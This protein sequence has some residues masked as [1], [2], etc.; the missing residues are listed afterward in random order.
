MQAG[1]HRLGVGKLVLLE[2]PLAVILLPIVIHHQ[3]SGGEP[4]VPNA[5][6][7]FQYINL[8][9]VIHQLDPG[10]ILRATKQQL[11]GHPR[12][13]VKVT[14]PRMQEG[15]AQR[16]AGFASP[17][18]GAVGLD[19]QTL[20]GC[21]DSQGIFRPDHI[22]LAR[23][24]QGLALVAIGLPKQISLVAIG[25]RHLEPVIDYARPPIDTRRMWNPNSARVAIHLWF[26]WP[27]IACDG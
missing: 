22:A 21:L 3:Y 23:Q 1:D 17:Q 5:P 14:L 20:L 8:V 26:D 25:Q 13:A 19:Q 11:I 2:I 18:P 6:G 16:P 10:I 9:L 15:L 4:V 12:G 24:Q 7:I 27:R